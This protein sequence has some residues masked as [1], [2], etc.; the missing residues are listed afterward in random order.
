MGVLIYI[1]GQE[2]SLSLKWYQHYQYIYYTTEKLKIEDDKMWG[3]SN[4]GT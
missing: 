1:K 4:Y 3:S 2:L